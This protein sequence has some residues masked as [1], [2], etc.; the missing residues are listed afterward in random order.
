MTLFEYYTSI[1][2]MYRTKLLFSR[3]QCFK[4]ALKIYWS[5]KT[6]CYWS[7]GIEVARSCFY[8]SRRKRNLFFC[9]TFVSFLSGILPI[10]LACI[11]S[12]AFC[13]VFSSHPAFK[14][15]KRVLEILWFK[16]G[17]G[18]RGSTP[19]SAERDW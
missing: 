19:R 17:M 1:T 11:V 4:M 16:G 18:L 9:K 2:I 5:V 7:T 3:K 15:R 12:F 14:T 10:I 8:L 6:P 13:F